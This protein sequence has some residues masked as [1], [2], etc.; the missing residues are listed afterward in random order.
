MDE[1]KKKVTKIVS[2]LLLVLCGIITMITV[3][4]VMVILYGGKAIVKTEDARFFRAEKILLVGNIAL[5]NRKSESFDSRD[6][7]L[8]AENLSFYPELYNIKNLASIEFNYSADDKKSEV[9]NQGSSDK[10]NISLKDYL[11]EYKINAAGNNG[12]LHL[13]VKG[14]VVY[15]SVRFPNWGRG[16]IEPLKNVRITNG[17][18]R[19]TRSAITSAEMKNLGI[20][21][22]FTQDYAGT[23][24]HSGNSIKGTYSVQGSRKEWEA[25]RSK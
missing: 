15:G 7:A 20:T 5:M 24:I 6:K 12:F 8:D 4:A 2:I 13:G 22:P 14:G 3:I 10:W 17:A 25:I 23:Y 19:F 11:G 18:I 16:V 1:K 9:Q 21:V